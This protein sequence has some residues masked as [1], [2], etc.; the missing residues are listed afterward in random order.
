[1]PIIRQHAS[2]YVS[3]RQLL[4]RQEEEHDLAHFALGNVE[5]ELLAAELPQER[6]ELVDDQILLLAQPVASRSAVLEHLVGIVV[7]VV[8]IK[9][10]SPAQPLVLCEES[11]SLG[12]EVALS[13][14]RRLIHAEC[15]KNADKKS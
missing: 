1:L 7:V 12:A 4:K 5:R 11:L 14:Q 13:K 6:V 15:G 10:L 8:V 3:I 2:A 9:H